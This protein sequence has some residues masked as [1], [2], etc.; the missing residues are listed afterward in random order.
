MALGQATL[1]AQ[2][3]LIIC[4]CLVRLSILL[5]YRRLF[6]PRWFR[7]TVNGLMIYVTLLGIS[8]FIASI[9]RCL[10]VGLFSPNPANPH[11]FNQD[12]FLK[13]AACLGI[14]IDVIILLIPLPLVWRLQTT[15]RRRIALT[16]IFVVGGL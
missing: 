3:I 16:V 6:I 12:A 1:A 4:L 7:R 10:P 9:L 13:T 15:R 5:L 8:T 2:A 14:I 11:C